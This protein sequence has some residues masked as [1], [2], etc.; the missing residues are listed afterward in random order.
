MHFSDDRVLESSTTS[1]TGPFTL[2]GALPGHNVFAAALRP[3]GT[4][5]QAGDTFHGVV[6]EVDSNGNSNGKW[7][8]GILTLTTL[9]SVTVTTTLRSSNSNAAETFGSGT[10]YIAPAASVLNLVML[11]NTNTFQLPAVVSG[12]AAVPPTG[13]MGFFAKSIGGRLMPAFIGSSGL[14]SVLQPHMARNGWAQWIPAG[15]G[16][17]IQ[18][19]G[20]AALSATGTA[21]AAVYATTSLHT[22][23]RRVDYLVTTAA[24]TAVAG[25]RIATN[26]YRG[27]EGYHHIFR[28]SPATG[29][30]VGT[31][32]FFCGVAG[33]TGAPTDVNP[34]TQTNIVGYGYDAADS[35]WQAMRND[36]SGTATKVD[37]GVARPST[38][39]AGLWAVNIFVPPGG[40]EARMQ[41]ID[42]ASGSLVHEGTYT[43]DIP[44][45]TQTMG[46]RAYHSVGGTSS[47]VGLTLF[48]GYM[49][50][51]N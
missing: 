39:R 9:T 20:A 37:T 38:D 22:R 15:T 46:P 23:A 42:E 2:L 30:T 29:G 51:D 18:A 27:Q 32:R 36:G 21:T 10:K 12:G 33:A 19:T 47:V 4:A 16:T 35:N 1:G 45:A 17:T 7:A 26:A 50:T 11:D 41:L 44:A 5:V 14:D 8:E 34:S 49:E 43:T 48:S 6:F 40:T 25:Y 3:D 24:T 13:R 31:R 28:V